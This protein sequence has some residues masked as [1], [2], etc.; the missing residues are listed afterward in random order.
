MSLSVVPKW[1]N[2][3]VSRMKFWPLALMPNIR[4]GRHWQTV[5]NTLAYYITELTKTDDNGLENITQ[6]KAGM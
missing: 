3:C 1:G 2:F 6:S 4:L 5:P